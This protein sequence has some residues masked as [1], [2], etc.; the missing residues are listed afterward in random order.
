MKNLEVEIDVK[1]TADN[2]WPNYWDGN[3]KRDFNW[4]AKTRLNPETGDED[5]VYLKEGEDLFWNV[6]DVKAGDILVFGLHDRY[7]P[8]YNKKAYYRVIDINEERMILLSDD[9]EKGFT[10]IRKAMRA[11][12]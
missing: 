2:V 10:T 1:Y 11:Q 8:R 4:A 7:K 9:D 3:P 5:R 12:I 6:K